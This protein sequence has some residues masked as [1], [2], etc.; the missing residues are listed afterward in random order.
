MRHCEADILDPG[1]SAS[2]TQNA[3][4]GAPQRA[5]R[6]AKRALVR[7]HQAGASQADA[8]LWARAQSVALASRQPKGRRGAIRCDER[9][10]C[11]DGHQHWLRPPLQRS[12]AIEFGDRL[13]NR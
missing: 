12:I 13:V 9:A 6:R 11:F 5:I 4:V 10:A 3:T 2:G 7:G 8:T 1:H